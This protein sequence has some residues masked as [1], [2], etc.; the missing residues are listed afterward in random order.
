MAL[1]KC[2]DCGGP[3]SDKAPAC[4]KCGAPAG[5]AARGAPVAVSGV[6]RVIRWLGMGMVAVVVFSC[7]YQTA[8]PSGPKAPQAFNDADANILCRDAIMRFSRDPERT[9]VPYAQ[10]ST[11]GDEALLAWNQSSKMLRMRNGLGLEVPATASCLVSRG[12]R[13]VIMLTIN[14]EA[15]I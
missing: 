15:M 5:R 3:V 2:A 9:Q 11:R 4:P 13:R 14:G 1:L 10:P 12:E 8:L 6:R 7:V